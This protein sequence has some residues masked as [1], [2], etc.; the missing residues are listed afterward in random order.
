MNRLHEYQF[1][2]DATARRL[3]SCVGHEDPVDAEIIAITTTVLYTVP[4]GTDDI[5]FVPAEA[6][7]DVRTGDTVRLLPDRSNT[8]Q[9]V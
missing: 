3:A 9:T 7:A 5:V 4:E 1:D 6:L 8:R 2:D